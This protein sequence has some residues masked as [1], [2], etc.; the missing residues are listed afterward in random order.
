MSKTWEAT[1]KDTFACRSF[2]KLTNAASTEAFVSAA[3]CN[4]NSRRV[5]RV[6][7][8][9]NS[10]V[11]GIGPGAAMI[12]AVAFALAAAALEAAG[13]ATTEAGSEVLAAFAGG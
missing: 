4:K 9:E 8:D 13:V 11:I 5:A 6:K 7:S 2:K 12:G 3:H 1:A 10:S